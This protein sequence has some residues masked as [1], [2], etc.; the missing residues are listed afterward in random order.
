[1]NIDRD[2]FSF[3]L[4]DIL[5]SIATADFIAIDF[6][7]SGVASNNVRRQ[8]SRRIQTLQERYDEVRAAACKYQILQVGITTAHQ[9]I[10][11]SDSTGSDSDGLAE[12]QFELRTYNIDL[13]PIVDDD[14]DIDR[15]FVLQSGAAEF[16][17]ANRFNFEKPFAKGVRYLSRLEETQARL[18]A[19][20]KEDRTRFSDIQLGDDDI[21][22]LTFVD[23]VRHEI[24][25]WQGKGLN[26]DPLWII[27]RLVDWDSAPKAS[28]GERMSPEHEL[29][30]FDRKL[31]HQL[32]RAE[33]PSLIAASKRGCMVISRID[34]A[35]ERQLADTRSKKANEQINRHIGFRWIV[36]ALCGGSIKDINLKSLA[37]DENGIRKNFEFYDYS[38]RHTDIIRKI[39][40]S[41]PVLVGH[42]VFGD[43][44]YLY[45]NFLGDLPDSVDQFGV[46]VRGMFPLVIDTKYMATHE[47]DIPG[48]S[49]LEQIV[50]MLD[51]QSHPKICKWTI[52]KCLN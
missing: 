31:V 27:S 43:I 47:L 21:D 30:G 17:L 18:A 29:T 37:V 14:L 2:N 48:S 15:D 52:P 39:G 51:S 22:A 41:R 5:E 13:C 34:A 23:R 26:A 50:S 25:L 32:L 19:K 33:F 42:N 44:C 9:K 45:Q 11:D 24:T 36:E 46:L 3:H 20:N 10:P 12:Q 16:L 40:E 28:L 6:E 4:L 49:S 8:T 35:K 38:R 1:M 7:F